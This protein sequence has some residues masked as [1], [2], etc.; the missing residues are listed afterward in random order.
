MDHATAQAHLAVIDHGALAGC[1]GPLVFTKA[2]FKTG[3]AIGHA[4]GLK[5]A[6]GIRLPVARFGGIA[7]RLG[8][9]ASAP[10]HVGRLQCG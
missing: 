9:G 1:D 6:G 2:Q 4:Q 8:R 3:L 7:A 10:A 5:I